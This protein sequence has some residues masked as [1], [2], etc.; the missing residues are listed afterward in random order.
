MSGFVFKNAKVEN[1]VPLPTVDEFS[2]MKILTDQ[3]SSVVPKTLGSRRKLSDEVQ[4][5]KDRL[6]MTPQ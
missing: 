3:E 6:T 4:L 2:S 1:Y 5:Y